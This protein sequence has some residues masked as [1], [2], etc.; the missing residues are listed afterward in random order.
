M[1]RHRP[2]H[3]FF[4]ETSFASR[5]DVAVFGTVT[6][7]SAH[8]ERRVQMPFAVWAK[9]DGIGRVEFIQIVGE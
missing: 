7:E 1:R 5:E 8:L 2:G 3:K 6:W 9:V 4:V